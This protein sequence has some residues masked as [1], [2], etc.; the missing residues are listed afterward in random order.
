MVL[1]LH[2][3][4]KTL[5]MVLMKETIRVKGTILVQLSVLVGLVQIRIQIIDGVDA[6]AEP[7]PLVQDLMEIIPVDMV[8][9]F[10]QRPVLVQERPWQH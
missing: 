5:T 10:M 7:Q 3:T 9:T 4:S 8:A 1:Q 2:H 6:M